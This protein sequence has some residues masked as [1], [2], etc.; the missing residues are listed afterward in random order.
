MVDLKRRVEAEI[1]NILRA[2]KDLKAV[3]LVKKKTNVE[4]AAIATFLLNIYNGM[5]NILKQIL[6][7]RGIKINRS[8]TWHKE[9]LDISVTQ[10]LITDKLANELRE[11]LAFRHFFIHSYGFMLEERQLK[12]LTDRISEVW[13]TFSSRIDEVVKESKS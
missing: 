1:E 4:L 8:E 13:N 9:L 5:E 6:K 10:G 7:S 2:Q 3:L 11:Y 12:M